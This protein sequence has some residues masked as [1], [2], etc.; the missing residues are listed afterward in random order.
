MKHPISAIMH[1]HYRKTFEQY[2]ETSM[3][4]DWGGK[5]W[6]TAIRNQ[7]MLDV[8][9]NPL[10]SC[11]LLDVGCGYGELSDFIKQKQLSIEYTGVDVVEGMIA[12]AKRRSQNSTFFHDDFLE[13]DPPHKYDYVV[14]NGIL[15]QKLTTSTLEMNE[16]ARELIKKMFNLANIGVAFN[17]MTTFVNFQKDNLYYRSP[18]EMLAWCMSEVTP[19]VRLDAAYELWYEYTVYLYKRSV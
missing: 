15:T 9:A 12:A 13:W 18:S 19:H 8:L 2:G 4:V 3:G 10:H 6:A 1:D 16:Y 17:C 7:N 5:D 11:T 14:C